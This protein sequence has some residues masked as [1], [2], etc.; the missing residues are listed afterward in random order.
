VILINFPT[1]KVRILDLLSFDR[2]SS[3]FSASFFFASKL[4][5]MSF[6]VSLLSSRTLRNFF[7][8][9]SQ[10]RYCLLSASFFFASK[11]LRMSFAV[12][13]LSRRPLGLRIVPPPLGLRIVP[14]P[15]GLRIVPPPLGLR[16]VFPPLGLRIVP[17]PPYYPAAARFRYCPREGCLVSLLSSRRPLR[18]RIV[19]P[20]LGFLIVPPP[21]ALL[22]VPPP[23]GFAI[24]PPKAAWFPY[25]PPEGRSVCA[26]SFRRSVSLLSPRL[27]FFSGHF[28]LRI[29]PSH[30]PRCFFF[31]GPAECAKRLNNIHK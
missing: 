28:E 31:P 4:L 16:I 18:L 13:L 30:H 1:S 23:L 29:R 20:Q 5:R 9:L 24:V 15:L 10:F 3:L 27:L 7:A 19:L 26:L 8:C 22:I 2:V 21:L 25:Y 14:P 17:P 11:L 6:A 12:S